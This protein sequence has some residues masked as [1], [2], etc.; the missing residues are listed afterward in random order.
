MIKVVILGT[1]GM[2][3]TSFKEKAY[4]YITLYKY[5]KNECDIK[6]LD[7]V[8]KIIKQIK[9]DY[10]I[11][12]AAYTNV[13]KA[14]EEI[15]KCFDTNTQAANNLAD[16]CE[17]N[18]IHYIVFST[19][20]IFFNELDSFNE[21]VKPKNTK[22]IYNLS[23]LYMEKHLEL[24]CKNYTI[25]RPNWMFGST[26]DHK[27]IGKMIKMLRN[28]E[29][30]TVADDMCGTYSYTKDIADTVL[31]LIDTNKI[32][33]YKIFHL[34]NT[35]ITN[36]FQSVLYLKELLH[37]NSQVIPVKNCYF[38]ITTPMAN[39]V[40]G[41]SSII[42]LRDWKQAFKSFVEDEYEV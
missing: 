5:I 41:V 38:N 14:E 17:D 10:L 7:Q 40:N 18:N 29:N 12:L 22:G 8:E 21:Q 42:K 36:R 4:Q 15:E 16:L 20:G 26:I 13:V 2:V 35:G 34:T 28:N 37:S 3:G 39:K 23:K 33:Q 19:C 9:P 11:N 6:N 25:I 31:E 30:I 32:K 27:F 24:Y 1:N